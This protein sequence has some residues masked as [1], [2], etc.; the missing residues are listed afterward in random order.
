MREEYKNLIKALS[1]DAF[2][3]VIKEYLK[4]TIPQVMFSYVMEL[5]MEE[6][7]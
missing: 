6:M 2:R 3:N 4:T 7:I 1:V 5:M